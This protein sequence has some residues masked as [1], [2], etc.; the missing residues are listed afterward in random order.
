MQ[1]IS[2][3]AQRMHAVP[4]LHFNLRL[5]HSLLVQ[6]AIMSPMIYQYRKVGMKAYQAICVYFALFRGRN[7]DGSSLGLASKVILNQFNEMAMKHRQKKERN[8]GKT[9]MS[10]RKR[11]NEGTEIR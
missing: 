4:P 9:R 1:T 3:R 10:S 8:D 7:K 2:S 11:R 6:V 5:L